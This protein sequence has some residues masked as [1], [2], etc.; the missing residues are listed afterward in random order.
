MLV[1]LDNARD[2]EQVRPL[3]PGT[4]GCLVLVTSRRPLTG[5][6]V[7]DGAHPLGLDLFSVDEARDLLARHLGPER[8]APEPD[9]VEE[10]I[11]RCARLPLALAIVAARASERPGFALET[12]VAQLVDAARRLDVLDAGDDRARVRTAFS[13][14]YELLGPAAARLFRLLGRSPGPDVG[15]PAAASLLGVT[16]AQVRTALAE[17]SAAR[18]LTE[19]EPGRYAFHD[20]LR[21]YA[22]ERLEHIDSAADRAD[23]NRRTARPLR[24]QRA[25]RGV[26]MVPRRTRL[27]PEPPPP[28]TGAEEISDVPQALTWFSRE[29]P[30]LLAAV[31]GAVEADLRDVV[32]W[33]AW[34]LDN[35]LDRQG[36]WAELV[37]V[38]RAAVETTEGPGEDADHAYLCR[39]LGHAL[40][41]LGRFDDARTYL[42]LAIEQYRALG[43]PGAQGR[44]HT[45]FTVLYNAQD[46]PQKGAPACPGGAD[47]VPRGGRPRL[48]GER[49]ERRRLDVRTARRVR[50]DAG[51]LWGGA[52]AARG[53]R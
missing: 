40:G 1:V 49:P 27:R 35:Y 37:R 36:R 51:P 39:R 4:A 33:L 48:R 13:W 41:K 52:D 24:A 53:T 3:L 29:L 9:A 2:V 32:A 12:F 30:V 18:L 8:M 50:G 25:R 11:E 5:L 31:D 23:A 34:S 17:L 44:C 38:M 22:R 19:H 43:D 42:D 47:T 7:A 26:L 14:S 15:V 10:I 16:T 6:I 45:A 28:G 20:L 21:G 46:A